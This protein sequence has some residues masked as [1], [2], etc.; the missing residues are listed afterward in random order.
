MSQS[1]PVLL[2]FRQDLRLDDHAALLAAAATDRPVLP[3]FVLEDVGDWRWGGASRWWLHRSLAA[4]DA[5]LRRMGAPLVLRRGDPRRVLPELAA[6]AGA[7]TVHWNRRYEPDARQRD[8]ETS[9]ALRDAGVT[10]KA[11]P[12]ALLCEPWSLATGQGGPYQVFTPYHKAFL[13]DVSPAEPRGAPPR[14]RAPAVA[15]ESLPLAALDLDPGVLWGQG[16]AEAWTPGEAGG[17]ALLERFA[18]GPVAAYA[19]RRD[20]P[21]EPSTSRLSPHLHWGEVSPARVWSALRGADG[22]DPFLRQLVW[23]EFAHHLLHH[24]PHTDRHPLRGEFQDF[25]WDGDPAHLRAWRRGETGYPLVDAGM[26]ELWT[27]GW[28]HNR[29]RMVVASFLVKHLLL[30]WQEGAAWFWDTLVDADLANN[31]FG[32][33]WTAGCG[34]DAAPYFRVFNPM[35]QSRRFDPDGAYLRRWLPELAG[36]GNKAIHAPWEAS[37]AE[38]EGA[39]VELGRTYPRPLVEHGAARERALEAYKRLRGAS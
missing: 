13:R 32:W 20:R 26:R 4:L 33:Q 34:A 36:L 6:A 31:S 15:P 10:V 23:R 28:M 35:L 1:A 17:R 5:D 8:R 22:A 29:V 9:D 24:F 18:A 38:R 2:W 12:G 14:L 39:G 27:T 37:R 7:D 25:P 19:D 3:V 11:H 21:A 16:M 30:P